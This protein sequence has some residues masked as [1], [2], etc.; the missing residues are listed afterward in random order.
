MQVMGSEY[1]VALKRDDLNVIE[2]KIQET[3]MIYKGIKRPC[4]DSTLAKKDRGLRE[5]GICLLVFE[6]N[7]FLLMSSDSCRATKDHMY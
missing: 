3:P 2:V 1:L 4:G 6:E 7:Y 5:C